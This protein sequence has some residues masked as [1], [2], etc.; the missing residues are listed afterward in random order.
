MIT[1]VITIYC[2]DFSF[3]FLFLTDH[4]VREILT[5][6]GYKVKFCKNFYA[7]LDFT[8]ACRNVRIIMPQVRMK[9]CDVCIVGLPIT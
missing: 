2:R 1:E 8:I 4:V 9:H 3:F 5:N 6:Y 7:V